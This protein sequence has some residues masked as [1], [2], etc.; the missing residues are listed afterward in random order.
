[1]Q[2]ISL[3]AVGRKNARRAVSLAA[4]S[5]PR[6]HCSKSPDEAYSHRCLGEIENSHKLCL[7]PQQHSP[8]GIAGPRLDRHLPYQRTPAWDYY[9]VRH[10]KTAR[11]ASS[12]IAQEYPAL[13]TQ[14]AEPCHKK[15]N[16]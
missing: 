8:H 16:C 9:L 4:E 3:L 5:F 2:P 15:I 6:N 13:Q 12:E 14:E 11:A 1:M 7:I 10:K